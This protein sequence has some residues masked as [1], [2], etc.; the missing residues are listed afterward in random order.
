VLQDVLVNIPCFITLD[1]KIGNVSGRKK[2][3]EGINKQAA[4]VASFGL[5]IE[6]LRRS[7]VVYENTQHGLF[8]LPTLY[9]L[10][11]SAHQPISHWKVAVSD[12]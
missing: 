11:P 12:I 2:D 9:L 1:H 8:G 7:L 10:T 6:A 4:G 5:V 3:P